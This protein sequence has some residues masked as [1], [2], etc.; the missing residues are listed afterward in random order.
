MSDE[1]QCMEAMTLSGLCTQIEGI[2]VVSLP[3]TT[4]QLSN[5]WVTNS[6]EEMVTNNSEDDIFFARLSA[7]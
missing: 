7:N 3:E 4:T 6:F 5:L 1:F 2:N